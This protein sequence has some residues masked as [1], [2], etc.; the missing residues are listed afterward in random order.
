[1][2][3]REE[4]VGKEGI[5]ARIV[6]D[7]ISNN[8][9]LTTFE[10]EYPRFIHGEV[11]THRVF[12]R[13]AS[14]S[15]AVPTKK[16][17]EQVKNNPAVP[18]YFGL[19]KPGMVAGEE[20][21]NRDACVKAWKHMA[22][23][24][25][26]MVRALD[27]QNIHKQIAARPLETYQM[28]KVVLSG[29]DFENFFWLRDDDAA[30]PEIRELAKVMR[31]AMDSNEPVNLSEG[32]WHTPYFNNG[33]VTASST[34]IELAK[35]ISASCCAQVSY[36]NL[37]DSIE[38]AEKIYDMLIKADKIHASPFEH[39]ATPAPEWKGEEWPEGVTH[40]NRNKELCSGNFRSWIQL[41]ALLP[42]NVKEG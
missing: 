39:I 12:S 9:R 15:R 32:D 25:S 18:V 36:R 27:E 17:I 29:T 33:Y 20:H 6:A 26:E 34:D 37:D 2:K 14:S 22:A 21:S 40:I 13:N 19:N 31:E 8:T 7:S 28:M 41:R 35:K 10:L 24:T 38:K 23:A 11:M 1:M 4:V 5:T 30:Q 42:N 3:Y 16:A